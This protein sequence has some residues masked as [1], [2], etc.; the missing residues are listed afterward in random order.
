MPGR[1][2]VG[3]NGYRYGFGGKEKDDEVKGNGNSYD[4]DARIYD[5]R[6]GRWLSL[7]P[8]QTKY[9]SLSPYN[10]AENN[11]IFFADPDGKDAIG[12]IAGNTITISATIYLANNQSTKINVAEAQKSI[13]QY[14]G[15]D[16]KYTD[17]K[18]KEYNVKFEI[19]V[20]EVSPIASENTVDEGTNFVRP[21]AESFRSRVKGAGG[22]YGRWAANQK[23]KTY[24]HEV[25]HM[26]GL[27]DQYVD[28]EYNA[29]NLDQNQLN[30]KRE[31]WDYESTTPD[32]VMGTANKIKA[33]QEKVSQK[34]IDAIASFVLTNQQDGKAVINNK[35]LVKDKKSNGLA[36]PTL[37]DEIKMDEKVSKNNRSVVDPHSDK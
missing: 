37:D 6:I 11:P 35:N 19:T 33:G 2:F 21:E 16:F 30:G 3:A 27:A 20:K 34:D 24:A 14:W 32:E 26:L 31:S 18:G 22:W 10:F 25:G 23:N 4:F 13:N 15:K 12:K 8:L 28:V 29:G 5:P 7:D 17:E 36:A 1:N 9:P